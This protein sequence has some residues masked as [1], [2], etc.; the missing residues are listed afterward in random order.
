MVQSGVRIDVVRAPQGY[1]ARAVR[2]AAGTAEWQVRADLPGGFQAPW[3][4]PRAMLGQLR[5]RYGDRCVEAA[6]RPHRALLS[7][8]LRGLEPTL[9]ADERR[10]RAQY[11]AWRRA[12]LPHAELTARRLSD[13]WGA[14][15]AP[16]L[17][18][19]EVHV[20]IPDIDALDPQS[21]ALLRPLLRHAGP[22]ARLRLVI[23]Q[24]PAAAQTAGCQELDILRTVIGTTV[25][26]IEEDGA[27]PSTT[28]AEA[29]VAIDP[30]DDDLEG[31]AWERLHTPGGFADPEACHVV[32][33]GIRAAF[34]CYGFTTV[35]RL[36]HAWLA[37][38]ASPPAVAEMHSMLAVSL[39]VDAVA[40]PRGEAQQAAAQRA[41][42]QLHRALEAQT[43]PVRRIHHLYMLSILSSRALQ[44][45][46]QGR[47]WA[48]QALQVLTQA[49]LPTGLTAFLGAW[50]E[51]AQAYSLFKTG[52]LAGAGALCQTA[53]GRLADAAADA[54]VEPADLENTR[55][56]LLDNLVHL[57]RSS[58][59]IGLPVVYLGYET[60]TLYPT[61]DR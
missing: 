23:G 54:E 12:F 55:F 39:A 56:Y 17:R 46:E 4:L 30:L 22:Q 37:Q 18:H 51:N 53:L 16:L 42:A 60:T 20:C 33:H 36:A 8:V 14:A 28:T 59:A 58:Y 31:Q 24:D 29:L 61:F 13:A 57:H 3:A 32:L 21:L 5:V 35:A 41:V 26:E 43:D 50:V 11:S 15:L 47:V 7:L 2:R 25:L 45:P 9:Q 49:A 19:E 40:S 1:L 34:A 27:G 44:Q 48:Q 6:L 10:L 38:Q 52:D